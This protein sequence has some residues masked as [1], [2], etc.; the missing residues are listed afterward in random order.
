MFYLS[1]FVLNIRIFF[2]KGFYREKK[3]KKLSA[4]LG[5]E[6]QIWIL[7]LAWG[8]SRLGNIPAW[9][10]ILCKALGDQ[11]EKKK[12]TEK[13]GRSITECVWCVQRDAW[14]ALFVF[15][16]LSKR[17]VPS[18]LPLNSPPVLLSD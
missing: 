4:G 14:M 2:K 15:P 11:I 16:T 1:T 8:K 9:E 3:N 10:K 6:Q 13:L 12:I 18:T 17:S 5:P 7:L